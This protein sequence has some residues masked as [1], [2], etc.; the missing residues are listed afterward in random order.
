M[1]CRTLAIRSGRSARLR[2]TMAIA[3]SCLAGVAQAAAA[4]D[5]YAELRRR[6][7]AL[8]RPTAS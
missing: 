4:P 2:L 3:A 8:R 6:M 7:Q 1:H 5:R